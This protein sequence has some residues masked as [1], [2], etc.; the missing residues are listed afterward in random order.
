MALGCCYIIV[1]MRDR[2][3]LLA[4]LAVFYI[5][6]FFAPNKP[7]YF[8]SYFAVLPFFYNLTKD[9]SKSLVYSLILSIFSEVGIGSSLFV[10]EPLYVNPDPGWMISPM[11]I[12]ILITFPFIFQKKVK[13][14]LPDLLILFFLLWSVVTLFFNPYEN[15]LY[16]IIRTGEVILV[17][18]ILRIMLKSRDTAFIYYLLLSILGFLVLL[19]GLQ[20]IL[21]RN[22]GI[23]AE[24]VNITYPYGLTAVEDINLFRITGLSGHANLFAIDLITLLPFT[25]YSANLMIV[26]LSGL[27][28]LAFI[29]THS[30]AAWAIGVGILVLMEITKDRKDRQLMT[31]DFTRLFRP[32]FYLLIIILSLPYIFIRLTSLDLAFEEG[33]SFNVR[34]KIW[35][36]ALNLF[37]RYPL[38]GIGINRF[39]QVASEEPVTNIFAASRFTPATKIH[40]LFIEILTE[41]GFIGLMIFL[42]FIFSVYRYYFRNKN[43]N[44]RGLNVRRISFFSLTGLILISLLH[45]FFQTPQFRLIFLYSA[46]ILTES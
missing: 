28:F 9:I 20:F 42:V 25:I 22:I 21:Q 27:G 36:E 30:R 17:Y 4:G 44:R 15:V 39:Q 3:I 24:S 23:I 33:G 6:Q 35:S 37:V 13:V 16:G 32:G 14:R 34:T 12:L 8:L 1:P 2:K 41:T 19:G 45:P 46:V 38:T 7:V 31:A 10:M 29:F 5:I 18:F 43:I 11:T 40:N 26:I